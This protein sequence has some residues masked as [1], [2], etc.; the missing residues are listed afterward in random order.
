MIHT[1][2][3]YAPKDW[4]TAKWQQLV[5][6]LLE[7]YPYQV[8]EIGLRSDLHIQHPRY[9]NLCGQLTIL[10][11]AE[12]IRRARYFIGLDSGPSHL[13]NAAGTFGFI[14]MGSLNEFPVYNPYSGRYGRQEQCVLIREQGVPC[15]QLSLERVQ[16]PIE[17]VL[18]AQTLPS[19]A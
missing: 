1:Q 4:P 18:S 8:V 6:W 16:Q 7:K 12:V 14:L 11:T 3:N 19:Q 9:R 2:S 17:K 15:A 13:A 5:Q 10:E